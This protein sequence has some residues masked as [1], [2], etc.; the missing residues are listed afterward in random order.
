MPIIALLIGVPLFIYGI[1]KL[2]KTKKNMDQSKVIHG[3]IVDF[4]VERMKD[5]RPG[6]Y[7]ISGNVAY[8]PVIEYVD[9]IDGTKKQF[10]SMT[11]FNKHKHKLGEEIELIYYIKNNRKEVMINH[12]FVVWGKGT[13][14]LIAGGFLTL[15]G[16][17]WLT[18]E[19]DKIQTL[20]M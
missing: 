11:G 5:S 17:L 15:I 7:Q 16:G 1:F 8:F 18:S 13:F 14:S 3:T 12:W 20:F 2:V 4:I 10:R 19:W 6:H 9:A